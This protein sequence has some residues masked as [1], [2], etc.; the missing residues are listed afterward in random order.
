MSAESQRQ[1]CSTGSC[2]RTGCSFSPTLIEKLIPLIPR[3]RAHLVRYHGILGPAAEDRDKVVPDSTRVDY[4][5]GEAPAEPS[6][7]REIDPSGIPRLNRLPWVVLL[8][9]VFLVDVLECP[10]TSAACPPSAADGVGERHDAIR[11]F[12]RRPTEP[13][14][15]AQ[16]ARQGGG[17]RGAAATDGNRVCFPPG[18]GE[19]AAT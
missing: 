2:R 19:R 11:R 10:A 13:G 14:G 18:I 6:D 5:R 15:V 12:L 4:G 8:K 1:A 17:V 16:Q 7:P 9:R 3:P